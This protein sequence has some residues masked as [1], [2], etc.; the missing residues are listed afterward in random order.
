[1][2][3]VDLEDYH[4]LMNRLRA[5]ARTLRWKYGAA[6]RTQGDVAELLGWSPAK[7]SRQINHSNI[8]L[9]KFIALAGAYGL[10]VELVEVGT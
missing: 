1:M 7:V 8:T 2:S 4:T 5:K 6:G 10:R 3:Q 9:K